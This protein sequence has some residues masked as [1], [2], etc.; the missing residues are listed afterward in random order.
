MPC[1]TIASSMPAAL[2]DL[3]PLGHLLCL[4]TARTHSQLRQPIEHNAK[5]D[6]RVLSKM[7]ND[8]HLQRLGVALIPIGTQLALLLNLQRLT[9]LQSKTLKN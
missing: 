2:G 8:W 6:L 9:N 3:S 5:P 7:P 4:S 1:R